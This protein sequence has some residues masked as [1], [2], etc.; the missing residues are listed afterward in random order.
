MK[1][2]IHA[3]YQMLN[4]IFLKLDDKLAENALVL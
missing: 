3:L 2:R 4:Y 1:E